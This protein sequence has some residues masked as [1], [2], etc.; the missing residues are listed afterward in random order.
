M[1]VSAC[2]TAATLVSLAALV[3]YYIH[4]YQHNTVDFVHYRERLEF[5]T[6]RAFMKYLY[7]N[8]FVLFIAS[9]IAFLVSIAASVANVATA[10]FA[11]SWLGLSA[12]LLLGAVRLL[13]LQ[14][15]AQWPRRAK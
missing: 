9:V 6:S 5:P 2:M 1:S 11:W 10:R 12:L 13:T 14:S 15:M 4:S 8:S 3:C 7:T